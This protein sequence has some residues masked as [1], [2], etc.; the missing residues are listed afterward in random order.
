MVRF[1]FSN[2]SFCVSRSFGSFKMSRVWSRVF[3]IG[4][5]CLGGFFKGSVGSVGSVGIIF[6]SERVCV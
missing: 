4:C 2:F 3:L 6:S 5:E 1:S